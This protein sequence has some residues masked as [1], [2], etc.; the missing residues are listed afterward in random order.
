MIQSD[1]IYWYGVS[2]TVYIVTCWVFAVVRWFHTCRAPKERRAY[3]W[4]DRK[5]QVI[6]FSMA[7]ILLPYVLNPASPT[8]WNLWKSYFPGTNYF[9]SGALLFCYFGSVKQWNR[10]R[11][12]TWIAAILTILIMAPLILDAWIPGGMMKPNGVRLWSY[13]FVVVSMGLMGYSGLA[14][15]QVRRWMRRSRDENYSNPDDFPSDYAR[16][17]WHMPVA[18]TPFVWTAYI[19]DSPD[20]MAVLN[21][22]LAI[23]NVVLLLIVMPPWRRKA[24]VAEAEDAE[25]PE[26]VDAD[27]SELADARSRRIAEEIEAY[28]KEGQAF[29]NPHLK[30]DQVVEHCSYSRTYVSHVFKAH[31]GGFS[32]YVNKLRLDYYDCYMEQHPSATK[33]AAAQESGFTGYTAYYKVKDRFANE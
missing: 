24:F 20:V 5:L 4:P 12:A 15:W 6:I 2:A 18:L 27:H 28:V 14:M 17:V 7:T 19:L 1:N 13:V 32:H 31:F 16:Y 10:W 22:L 21:I 26:K 30:I 11:T 25:G 8:A 9:Y 29:L 33:D 23:F 3:I